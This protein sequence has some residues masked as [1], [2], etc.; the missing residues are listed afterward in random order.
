[1][2][3]S[4]W[5]PICYGLVLFLFG[6][7]VMEVALQRWAGPLLHR[8]LHRATSTPLKGMIASTAV[9]ALLQSSTAVTVLA[10]GFANA[11]L[12]SFAGTLGIILGTN[13]GT[14][15]T[16]ELISLQIGQAAMPLLILS[17][18]VWVGA[19]LLSERVPASYDRLRITV[20][21]TQF[22]CLAVAGFA[23]VLLAIQYM[24]SIGPTLQTLGLFQWFLDHAARSVLWGIV[25]GALLTALMHSSAA[26]IAMAMGL[27]ASGALPPE[28]GVAVVLGSN[29]GTCVTA[30]IA[31]LGSS[32]AGRFVA[33]SHMGLNVGG[34]MLFAPFISGLTAASGYFATDPA[35]QIAHAQTLFNLICSLIALPLCYLPIWKRRAPV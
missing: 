10:I 14:T 12:L 4:L 7:K 24:Q 1:M 35:G 30:L 26:V 15:V 21:R 11:G 6:M 28:L 25:A 22:L 2:L 31:A 9:T 16:T 34:V 19:V 8:W 23:L 29:V 17:L 3:S 20:V 5:F 32:P 18:M 33:W 13:I 27:A